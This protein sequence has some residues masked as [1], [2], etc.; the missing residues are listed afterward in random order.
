L[1]TTPNNALSEDDQ[2]FKLL[3]ITAEA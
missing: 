1:L 3:G 2:M